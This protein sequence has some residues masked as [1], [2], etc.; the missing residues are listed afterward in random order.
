MDSEQY[1]E[2]MVLGE[3]ATL[4][5]AFVVA[6]EDGRLTLRPD[7]PVADGVSVCVRS[8]EDGWAYGRVVSVDPEVVV[9]V[10]GNRAADRRE[11]FRVEGSIHCKYQ[12]LKGPGHDLA[13]ERWVQHG[14]ATDAEWLTP[15]PF[16]DFS[17]SGLKFQHTETCASDDV[18]LLEVGVPGT[19]D[20][21]RTTARVVRLF[22]LSQE[23][24]DE[25]ARAGGTG[26]S[27]HAVA[28]HFLEIAPEAIEA[29]VMWTESIQESFL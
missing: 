4:I 20:T 28:V 25:L 15:D 26:A 1:V 9:Q 2:M 22:P 14:E 7:R 10:R 24:R 27:T 29:L 16:M 5:S 21:Y 8:S 17:A 11:F 13:R 18:L 19:D 12:V 6:N 3:E 23:E